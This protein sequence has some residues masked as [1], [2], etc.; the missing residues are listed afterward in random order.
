MSTLIW[1]RM[2][3]FRRTSTNCFVRNC[4]KPLRLSQAVPYGLRKCSPAKPNHSMNHTVGGISNFLN[5][6]KCAQQTKHTKQS[7]QNGINWE[8]VNKVDYCACAGRRQ[9]CWGSTRMKR[10]LLYELLSH[11]IV[12]LDKLNA[13]ANTWTISTW[14]WISHGR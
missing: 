6:F 8:P 13:S 11:L 9:Q 1:F 12:I 14:N 5:H 7:N 2:N 10:Y 3:A 4:F